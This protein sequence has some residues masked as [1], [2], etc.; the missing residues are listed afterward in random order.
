MQRREMRPVFALQITPVLSE[1]FQ[2]FPRVFNQLLSDRLAFGSDARKQ[3][4]LRPP[5]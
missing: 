5:S 1:P 4:Q 3:A 2:S